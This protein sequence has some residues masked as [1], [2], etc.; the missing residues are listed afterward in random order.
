M[1]GKDLLRHVLTDEQKT[2]G[3]QTRCDAEFI[4][5]LHGRSVI[6]IY[7]VREVFQ[8]IKWDADLYLKQGIW[9]LRT[10]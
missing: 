3:L 7:P 4:Y 5:L 6:N 10:N 2:K 8:R 1:Y 9:A